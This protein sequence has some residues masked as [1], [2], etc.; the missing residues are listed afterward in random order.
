MKTTTLPRSASSMPRV[1][2]PD[3]TVTETGCHVWR[4]AKQGPCYAHGT[5]GCCLIT[6]RSPAAQR[7]FMQP[8]CGRCGRFFSTGDPYAD[9]CL[10]CRPT[11]G[12]S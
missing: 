1:E 2:H 8:R 9:T 10:S 11:G 12:A 7:A 3:L 4:H 5:P 6:H